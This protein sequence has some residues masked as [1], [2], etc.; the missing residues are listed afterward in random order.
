MKVELHALLSK[1]KTPHKLSEALIQYCSPD[2]GIRRIDFLCGKRTA[3]LE[4]TC[5][6]ET[7]SQIAAHKLASRFEA[8][9]FGDRCVFFE[10]PLA[11][12]FVCESVSLNGSRELPI[13]VSCK[14]SW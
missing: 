8:R 14:C 1:A 10:V 2:E 12:N 13:S 5:F 11:D 6:I 7:H 3:R 9:V 4:M